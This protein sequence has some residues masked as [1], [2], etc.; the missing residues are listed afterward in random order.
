MKRAFAVPGG[1]AGLFAAGVLL[2]AVAFWT[3]LIT[4]SQWDNLWMGGSYTDSYSA[5]AMV[6]LYDYYAEETSGLLQQE[7]WDGTLG[8]TERKRLD[9]LKGMLDPTRTNYRAEVHT[10]DGALLWSN[11][12]E[13]AAM[14]DMYAVT[15][16][17]QTLEKIRQRAL[18]TDAE[19]SCAAQDE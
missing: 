14:D 16:S 13:G 2:C 10:Q 19:S 11:L 17:E 18:L 1:R 8:Y 5:A 7:R 4:L 12:P 9:S 6:R 15:L 3:G